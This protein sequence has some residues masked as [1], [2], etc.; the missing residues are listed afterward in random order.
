[1]LSSVFALDTNLGGFFAWRKLFVHSL[2]EFISNL[3]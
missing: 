2:L 3:S 1:M